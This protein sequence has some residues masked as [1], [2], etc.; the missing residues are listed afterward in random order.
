VRPSRDEE[1]FAEL[2]PGLRRF[3]AVYGPSHV[4][5]DDLV[6]E[7]LLRTLQLHQL[8]DLDDPRLYLSKAIV[9]LCH[10]EQ[11][12]SVSAQ[13]AATRLAPAQ[14]VRQSYPSDTDFLQVLPPETRA[15]LILVDLEG[16]SIAELAKALGISAVSLRA[17]VSRA[18]RQLRS[19]ISEGATHE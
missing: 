17:R 13:D 18:R 6:Q 11:R 9:N 14:P 1:I 5:P 10:N 7:A 19:H 2:Y 15:A 4:D 12:R 3:A 16:Y 8:S